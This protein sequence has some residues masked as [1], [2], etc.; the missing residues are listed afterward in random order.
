MRKHNDNEKT[1]QQRENTKTMRKTQWQ[2]E[3]TTAKREHND[4]W[5]NTMTMRKHNSKE[6]TQQQMRKHNKSQKHS[7]D[8]ALSVASVSAGLG[9]CHQLFAEPV[10]PYWWWGKHRCFT[11]TQVRD[12]SHELVL[13]HFVLKLMIS[14]LKIYICVCATIEQVHT[15]D[16]KT[17]TNSYHIC[18]LY[19]RQGRTVACWNHV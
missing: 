16:G 1:Q 7:T 13:Q 11:N 4:K 9:L 17:K 10:L 12:W 14:L 5:E 19:L 15:W 6:R 18:R 3:N 8:P 2:W